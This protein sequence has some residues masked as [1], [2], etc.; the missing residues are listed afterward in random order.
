MGS[1]KCKNKEKITSKT[2]VKPHLL[3]ST[4]KRNL[5]KKPKTISARVSK[6]SLMRNQ[7]LPSPS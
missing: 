5:K 6:S 3:E 4:M 7:I 1:H 2:T